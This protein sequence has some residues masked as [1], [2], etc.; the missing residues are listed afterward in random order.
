MICICRSTELIFFQDAEGQKAV[1]ERMWGDG[2]G[3]TEVVGGAAIQRVPLLRTLQW[4][5]FF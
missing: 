3:S 2:E 1:Q 4:R 5:D